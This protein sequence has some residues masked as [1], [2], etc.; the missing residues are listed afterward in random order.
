MRQEYRFKKKTIAVS[1]WNILEFCMSKE[2]LE[3][4]YIKC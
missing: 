3:Q 2:N 1:D 4:D